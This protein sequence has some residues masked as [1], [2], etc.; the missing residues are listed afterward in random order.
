M[1]IM[2][3]IICL[4]GKRHSGKSTVEAIIKDI[5]GENV[6]SYQMATIFFNIVAI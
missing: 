5:I 1:Y 2:K 3:T 6:V 4:N